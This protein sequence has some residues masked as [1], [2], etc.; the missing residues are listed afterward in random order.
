MDGELWWVLGG[1]LAV[2]TLPGTLVL[3]ML[4]LAALLP[5]RRPL[6]PARDPATLRLCVV[7]P[8]HNE[9][10]GIGRT[11]QS[12]LACEGAD[13][14]VEIVV[15]AD[16]CADDTAGAARRAGARVIER[17]D[18]ERRGKGWAL[19][20]AFAQLGEEPWEAFAVVDADTVVEPHL[21]RQ[22]RAAFVAG[23]DAAQVRYSTLDH[24]RSLRTRLLHIAFLGI[25]VVRPRGRERL[26]L[27]AGIVG[28][29]FALSRATLDRV[30]YR[31]AT[32]IVEDLEYHLRLVRAG[33]R[34][35]FVDDVAVRSEMPSGGAAAES[36]R[37]R[38]EGGRLLVLRENAAA[39]LGDLLRG[40]WRLLEPLGDL[41]LLPLAFHVLLLMLTLAVPVDL[42]RLYAAGGLGVVALHVLAAVRV[43]GGG[44]RDLWSLAAAPGYVVWKLLILGRIGR[45][46]RRSQEWVRTERDR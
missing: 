40:Q 28:N 34:V 33:Q 12:L 18:P 32:S 4:S 36:Q 10:S 5:R 23:A 1:V 2:A 43:G 39:L 22:L 3:L 15:V 9:E 27:S 25:N 30:P 26:G 20:F 38:W 37:T 14:G 42:I 6:V 46:A 44:L 35:R 7:V 13:V 17:R 19:D 31:A 21:L 45:A 24:E 11:V 16:N 29:G 41:L 8:A